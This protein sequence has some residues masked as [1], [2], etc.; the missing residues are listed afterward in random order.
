MTPFRFDDPDQYID[1]TPHEVFARLRKEAPFVWNQPSHGEGFW[2]ATRHGDVVSIS[3]HPTLFATNAPLL[4]NPLP[5]ELWS[6]YPA[7]AMI[8]DNLMTFDHQKHGILRSIG[9]SLFSGTRVAD[10]ESQVRA[11]CIEVMVKA[12]RRTHFDFANDVALAIP[13]EIVLGT[14]LGIDRAD[15]DMITRC[16][17]TINAVDDPVLSPSPT[18]LMDAAEELFA[19]G[20]ALLRRLKTSPGKNLLSELIHDSNVGGLSTEQL[21]LAYW[22]PLVAGAFDTTASTIAGGVEALLQF[23]EQLNQL[24]EAPNN[25]PLAVEEMLRWVSPVIYFR[26]TATSDTDFNG[27]RIRKGEKV[28]LCYASANRDE[29]VFNNPNCFDVK[30]SPNNHVSFGYGPHF[31]LGARLAL[32]I[33]RTFL[34]EFLSRMNIQMEG[35]ITR[36]RSGWMNRIRSM[37]VRNAQTTA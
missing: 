5:S 11:I 36:T 28:I 2:L 7:L 9:N 37:P 32:L 21:F 20:I 18:A 34:D 15:L 27:N 33:L 24:R 35:E 12:S 3:K 1:G 14:F 22:F 13:V 19:Y 25:I 10:V 31:C 26:R 6:T 16:V 29:E 30:R 8:A 4:S 17:L 23:P